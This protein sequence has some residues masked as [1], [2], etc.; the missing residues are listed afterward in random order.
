LPVDTPTTVPEAP[1]STPTS[2]IASEPTATNTPNLAAQKG[3]DAYIPAASKKHQDYHYSCEFDAAWVVFKTYGMDVSVDEQYSIMGVDTSIEPR[4]EET[5]DGIFIY[6]GDITNYYSGDMKKNFLARSSGSAMSKVFKHFGLKVTPV[7][8]R[9][10]V[11]SALLS[12][13]LIWVKV[14]VDFKTWRS[15]TWVMPDGRTYQTVLGNDHAV[16]I[17]GFNENVVVIRDVLGPTSSNWNRKYEY[18]VPW[19]KFMAAWGAQSYDGL[20]VAPP[21]N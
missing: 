19:E 20:A 3:Y 8:D 15:A 4:W 11:Q 5:K 7:H 14:P 2:G 10:S 1:A 18:E 13:S 9:Q 21:G 17:M 6:G 16:V 12:G